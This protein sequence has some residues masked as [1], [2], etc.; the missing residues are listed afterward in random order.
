MLGGGVPWLGTGVP[1]PNAGVPRLGAG[2]PRLGAGVPSPWCWGSLTL[3]SWTCMGA[4]LILNSG[5]SVKAHSNDRTTGPTCAG[6][7]NGLKV[8]G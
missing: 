4:M 7:Q 2:V 6:R 3:A 1:W 8:S 5:S